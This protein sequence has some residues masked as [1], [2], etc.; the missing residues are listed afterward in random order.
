LGYVYFTIDALWINT[1]CFIYNV[2]VNSF[3]LLF[4]STYQKKKIDLS[5]GSAFNYQGTSA[6]QFIIVL[7][8]MILPILIF[9]AFNI[10]DK[11]YYGLGALVAAGLIS[12]AFSKAWFNE[13]AKNFQEKKYKNAAGFREN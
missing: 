4:A 1:A 11:P 2:G 10:F 5:K 9:Q 8:L 6:T 13:I 12:L 7:P 3:V